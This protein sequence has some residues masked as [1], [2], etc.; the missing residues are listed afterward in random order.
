[1]TEVS[2]WMRKSLNLRT[3]KR[4]LTVSI[5]SEAQ[6]RIG[7]VRW[8]RVEDSMAACWEPRSE[9]SN[10][11][12]L[13][14]AKGGKRTASSFGL[15]NG[16]YKLWDLVQQQSEET[17]ETETSVGKVGRGIRFRIPVSLSDG[18]GLAG[19]GYS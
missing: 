19:M 9:G 13:S 17:R 12:E 16:A 8:R 15:R 7:C 18:F 4:V 2:L 3:H 6:S 1:M 5:W 11:S 10:E 14:K